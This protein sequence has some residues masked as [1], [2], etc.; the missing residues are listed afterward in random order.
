MKFLILGLCLLTFSPLAPAANRAAYSL[1]VV[2]LSPEVQVFLASP[3][4]AK[5]VAEQR[6]RMAKQGKGMIVW[7]LSVLTLGDKIFVYAYL[8][9]GTPGTVFTQFG[10][11][12]GK[13]HPS[14]NSYEVESAY[15]SPNPELPGGGASVGN[16]D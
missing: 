10:N 6:E 11:V 7:G 16:G 15:F 9:S 2:K 13:L 8:F 14:G 4:F 1:E 5:A 3:Q 12:V